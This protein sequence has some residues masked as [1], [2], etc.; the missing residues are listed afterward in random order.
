[1]DVF[2][3][4]LLILLLLSAAFGLTFFILFMI[5]FLKIRGG[6]PG[7]RGVFV[8]KFDETLDD[9]RKFWARYDGGN[10]KKSTAAAG[11]FQVIEKT[12]IVFAGKGFPHKIRE[13]DHIQIEGKNE[14][15]IIAGLKHLDLPFHKKYQQ[16]RHE[17]QK[18]RSELS[19]VKL[20]LHE[21]NTQIEQ[22]VDKKVEATVA[23][24]HKITPQPKTK[25]TTSS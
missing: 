3:W 7:S 15:L 14:T 5:T 13:D 12:G 25:Q 20:D 11:E 6:A 18:L 21:A 2:H 10:W 1:M 17:N 24:I 23:H 16:E 4:I 19:K 22:K 9:F 8:L